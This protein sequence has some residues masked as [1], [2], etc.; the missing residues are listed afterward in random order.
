MQ[1]VDGGNSGPRGTSGTHAA[2]NI[3]LL[4]PASPSLTCGRKRLLRV[5]AKEETP[6]AGVDV[7][8]HAQCRPRRSSPDPIKTQTEIPVR[9]KPP[10][11][12]PPVG[13]SEL[14]FEGEANPR[15]GLLQAGASADTQGQQEESDSGCCH[16]NSHAGGPQR[17]KSG[18]K[19]EKKHKTERGREEKKPR[20]IRK[21]I[22]YYYRVP[23]EKWET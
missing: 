18:Q 2:R 14:T 6:G 20:N 22:N 23:H 19:K 9:R 1:G 17:S 16:G 10:L 8:I 15:G 11:P 7:R 4:F 5:R 21:G 13:F 12:R 3:H